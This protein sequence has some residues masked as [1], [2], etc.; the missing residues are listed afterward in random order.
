MEAEVFMVAEAS[1]VAVVTADPRAKKRMIMENELMCSRDKE[2]KT[3]RSKLAGLVALA[4]FLALVTVSAHPALAQ[5]SPTKTFSSAGEASSALF[6]AAQKGDEQQ[7]EAILG[8]GKDVTSSGDELEDKL[9]REQFTKKYQ[10]MHRLVH[11]ADGS[12]ML[13]IGA[14]NWP[15]PIALVRSKGIW[16]FDSDA[17]RR[18]VLFRTIGENESIAIE[19][20][21][22]FAAVTKKGDTSK[23]GDDPIGDLAQKLFL[24]ST[25]NAA[26]AGANG[27][28]FHGY[29]FHTKSVTGHPGLIAYPAKYRSSGVMTFLVTGSGV[30]Y[31]KDLGRETA[32]IAPTIRARK[33]DSSWHP[34]E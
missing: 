24:R 2:L 3:L 26:D 16:H 14:E 15:F 10:E 28:I 19:V 25:T 33:L 22:A 27:E 1:M 23:T 30:V 4:F 8:V 20:C 12:T 31:E 29:Y 11:E 34:A 21:D 5:T 7:L 32:T 18:E 13:Y 9:E 17:G 6:Q